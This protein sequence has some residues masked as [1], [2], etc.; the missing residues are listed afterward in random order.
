MVERRPILR[1][2]YTIVAQPPME[3]TPMT[4]TMTIV[5]AAVISSTPACN[6]PN[7]KRG[8]VSI[9]GGNTN[10]EADNSPRQNASVINQ[11]PNNAGQFPSNP[12]RMKIVLTPAPS[13]WEASNV[14]VAS[15]RKTNQIAS[16]ANGQQKQ[17]LAST[18]AQMV[19]FC[20]Q[21][22]KGQSNCENVALI[23]LP[24]SG[25]GIVQ[26][27]ANVCTKNSCQPREILAS[28]ASPAAKQQIIVLAASP[29]NLEQF[30]PPEVWP[31]A[32]HQTDLGFE[33]GGA[34]RVMFVS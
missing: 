9:P 28:Q 7:N 30:L 18:G 10:C 14:P 11:Q 6:S 5:K 19:R 32:D 23:Q 24:I 21:R 8:M 34:T 31:I 4:L 16:G 26:L 20:N 22:K 25:P 12:N 1:W 15:W 17:T 13:N 2:L 27:S 33:P 29:I 3:I